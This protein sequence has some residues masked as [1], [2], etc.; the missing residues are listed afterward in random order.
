[1][2]PHQRR[3]G[4]FLVSLRETS[5]QFCVARLGFLPGGDETAE[6]ADSRM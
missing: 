6:V 2:P 5:Q 3:E 4:R 1:V